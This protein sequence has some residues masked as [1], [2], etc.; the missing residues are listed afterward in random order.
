MRC[1]VELVC[2]RVCACV[3]AMQVWEACVRLG[4]GK[5]ADSHLPPLHA[6]PPSHA[7]PLSSGWHSSLGVT[8]GPGQIIM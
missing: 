6:L 8:L 3:R 2:V 4:E 5:L 1:D 7:P